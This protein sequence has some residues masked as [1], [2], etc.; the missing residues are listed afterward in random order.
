VALPAEIIE[1][2][3]SFLDLGGID[4]AAR[5]CRA[6]YIH[7]QPV[8]KALVSREMPWLWEILENGE[9]PASR[10][11]P[12][13]WDP[14]CPPGLE[15]PT[16]PID[17]PS[18]EDEAMLWSEIVADDPEMEEAAEAAKALSARRRHEIFSP[19]HARQ[20]AAQREWHLFRANV[21]AWL[22][23]GP[24]TPTAQH[25][26]QA[27]NWRR[28]HWLCNP[29]TTPLPGL[30][31]RARI[32]EDCNQVLACV[33]VARDLG[34]IERRRGLLHEK[35]SDPSQPIWNTLD[36]FGLS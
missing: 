1:H 35:L 2:I 20:D 12:A 28:I 9:Y 26:G 31:N 4:A 30:R 5:T 34:A 14:L 8:F 25:H 36:A 21:E 16:L 23:Q 3:L 10:D 17:L 13:T 22:R 6:L 27:V 32:W 15:P 18:E 29:E 19:Y 33:S 11:W 7:T 24:Q